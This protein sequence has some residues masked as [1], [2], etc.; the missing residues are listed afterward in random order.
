LRIRNYY[1]DHA[2][3]VSAQSQLSLRRNSGFC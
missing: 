1:E 3:Q 2:L